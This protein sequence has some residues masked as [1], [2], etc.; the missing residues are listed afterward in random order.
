MVPVDPADALH[1]TGLERPRGRLVLRP[2][3]L[4][5]VQALVWAG[6]VDDSAAELP[7]ATAT[8]LIA[9]FSWTGGAA[10]RSGSEASWGHQ[11]VMERES[12]LLVGGIGFAG[13]PK[14]GEVEVGYGI[15]PSRQGVVTPPRRSG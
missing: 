6:A 15:V 13:L 2:L 5:V 14:H 9:A 8:W 12:G 10:A 7:A 1:A 3:T 4:A 11:Q